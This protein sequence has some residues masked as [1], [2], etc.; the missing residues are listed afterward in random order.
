MNDKE[1]F[2]TKVM[3]WCGVGIIAILILAWLSTLDFGVR[4]VLQ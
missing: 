2:S 3:F 4:I 1:E